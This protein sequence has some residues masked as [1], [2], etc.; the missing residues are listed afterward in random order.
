MLGEGIN[1]PALPM[2]PLSMPNRIPAGTLVPQKQVS[3]CIQVESTR[4]D[5]M[6]DTTRNPAMFVELVI[7]VKELLYYATIP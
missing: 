5:K 7:M 3:W 6:S 1:S 2:C 4:C